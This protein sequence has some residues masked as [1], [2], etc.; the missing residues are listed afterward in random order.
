MIG[1]PAILPAILILCIISTILASHAGLKRQQ[2][3]NPYNL[4]N[5]DIVFQD[6]NDAQ[7]KAVKAATNSRWPHVGIVFSMVGKAGLLLRTRL[8]NLQTSHWG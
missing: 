2:V 3:K 5:G 6:A 1:K 7:A 4:Q 8:E